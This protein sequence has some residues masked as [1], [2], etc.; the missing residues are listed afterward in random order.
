MSKRR[1][2]SVRCNPSSD[3]HQFPCRRTSVDLLAAHAEHDEADATAIEVFDD[4][5]QVRGTPGQT[6]RLGDD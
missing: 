1:A 2:M 5:Q 3:N 4:S 6:I